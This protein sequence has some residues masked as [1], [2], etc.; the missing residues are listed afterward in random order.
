MKNKLFTSF[1]AVPI[2]IP[3]VVF[4]EPVR[5]CTAFDFSKTYPEYSGYSH[6]F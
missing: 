5:Y 6:I 2:D 4:D 1:T 3:K